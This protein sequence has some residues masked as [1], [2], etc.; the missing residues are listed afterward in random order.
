MF[1]PVLIALGGN[2]RFGDRDPAT[3]LRLAVGRLA[4]LGLSGLRLGPL[5]RTAAFPPGTGPDYCNA[6]AR[7]DVAG[8][9]DA[10]ALLALLHRV[11]GEF[12]RTRDRRWGGRTLDLDLLAVGAQVLPAPS[13]WAAWHDLP[14]AEQMTRTP[15]QIILPHPRLQDRGFVLVPLCDVAPEWVHPVLGKTALALRDALPPEALGDI[16]PLGA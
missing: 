13:T 6:C 15:D 11:E 9:V 1:T 3:N 8:P 5:Y 4:A 7:A 16:Q 10:A 12:G 2:L 14:L